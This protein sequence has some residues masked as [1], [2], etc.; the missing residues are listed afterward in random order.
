MCTINEVRLKER[1][2]HRKKCVKVGR[3]ESWNEILQEFP[4]FPRDPEHMGLGD[5]APQS[6]DNGTVAGS[7][8]HSSWPPGSVSQIIEVS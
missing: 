6:V 4:L 7:R 2:I 8:E 1:N 5:P 3:E